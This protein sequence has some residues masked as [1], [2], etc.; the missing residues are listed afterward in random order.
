MQSMGVCR[1]V[2]KPRAVWEGLLGKAAAANRT[3]ANRP[4]GMRLGAWRNVAY[5]GT[6]NP[7]CN[8]KGRAVNPSPK[9]ARASVLSR[10]VVV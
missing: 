4:S 9:G 10:L 5:G 6:V 3:R 7:L 1:R 2:L 8:R